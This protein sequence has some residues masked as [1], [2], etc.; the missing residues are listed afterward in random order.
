MKYVGNLKKNYNYFQNENN[1]EE[2]AVFPPGSIIPDIVSDNSE[3]FEEYKENF[4]EGE[5]FGDGTVLK[6]EAKENIQG[7]GAMGMP[8]ER[9]NNVINSLCGSGRSMGD[10][11]CMYIGKK[12][13]A[14]FLFGADTYVK[15]TGILVGAGL[16]FLIIKTEEGE[17]TLCDLTDIKFITFE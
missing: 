8:G 6:M 17:E 2:K 13:S 12:V 7:M 1:S 5:L 16:N 10:F 15:K 14:E 9:E 4:N 11:L 3:N